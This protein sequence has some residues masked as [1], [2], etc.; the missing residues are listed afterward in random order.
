MLADSLPV[1]TPVRFN[2]ETRI[3][4]LMDVLDDAGDNNK[5][6]DFLEYQQTYL[7]A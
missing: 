7:E 2:A 4:V 3:C 5:A 1:P 6:V